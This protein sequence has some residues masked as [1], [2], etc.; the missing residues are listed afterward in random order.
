MKP[1]GKIA[2]V[3]VLACAVVGCNKRG[4][5]A[6]DEGRRIRAAEAVAALSGS[7]AAEAVRR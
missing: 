5:V 7:P 2:A 4:D 1:N 3:V 6:E